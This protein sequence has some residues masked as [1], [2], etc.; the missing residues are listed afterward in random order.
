MINSALKNNENIPLNGKSGL[1]I[2]NFYGLK[3]N[4]NEN[5]FYYLTFQKML[6]ID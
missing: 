3:L 5:Y 6:Y 4:A 2:S 1:F